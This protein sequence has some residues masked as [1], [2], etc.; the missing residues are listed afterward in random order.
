[1]LIKKQFIIKSFYRYNVNK[2]LQGNFNNF[3]ATSLM[4]LAS[5]VGPSNNGGCCGID[6]PTHKTLMILEQEIMPRKTE[7]TDILIGTSNVHLM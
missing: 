4:K 3:R 2:Y 1:M 7:I 6:Q 5:Y